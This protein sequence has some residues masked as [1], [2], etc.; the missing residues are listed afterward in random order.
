MRG[1]ERRVTDFFARENVGDVYFDHFRLDGSYGITD[2]D[3]GMCVAAGV[4][5]DAIVREAA[6]VQLVDELAFHVALEIIEM[7]VREEVLQFREVFLERI[8]TVDIRF[9]PAEQVE[10]RSVENEDS[11]FQK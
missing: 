1:D 6:F 9:A 7:D 2:G 3:G 5:D 10:V 8:A 4:E 11:H